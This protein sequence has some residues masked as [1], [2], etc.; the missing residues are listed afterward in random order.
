MNLEA[1]RPRALRAPVIVAPMFL[2]SGPELVIASCR[3]GLMGSFPTQNA[4]TADDLVRW[5]DEIKAG[6]TAIDDPQWAVSMIVH[7]TYDRFDR[8]LELIAEHQPTVVVTALGSPTR[9]MDTVRGYGGAVFADVMSVEHARKAADAGAD[10]LVLVCHGAGGH[11]GR[12]SPFAFVDEVRDF[13]DGTLVVGGAISTGRGVRAVETLGA[14]LAYMGTRFIA[15]PESLVQDSYRQ[16]LIRAGAGDVTATAGVTGVACSWLTESLR[17]AGYGDAQLSSTARIDFSD[18]HGE[19]KPWK[20]IFGA[21]QGVGQIDRIE[22]VGEVA[23]KIVDEY[24]TAT[25]TFIGTAS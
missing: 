5:L 18:V 10:G 17:D 20:D 22:T 12:L 8:E 14:E 9:V 2:V 19:Q 1:V 7:S 24:L 13:F 21:G 25:N 11:T 23:D 3:A 6:L 15:C 4:R 16:M